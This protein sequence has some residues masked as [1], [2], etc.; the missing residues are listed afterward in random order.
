M[1]AS[2]GTVLAWF[3]LM[4]RSYPYASVLNAKCLIETFVMPYMSNRSRFIDDFKGYSSN[5]CATVGTLRRAM[6]QIA[7][8]YKMH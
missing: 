1:L 7:K 8:S 4:P 3:S 6:D 5:V 2:L